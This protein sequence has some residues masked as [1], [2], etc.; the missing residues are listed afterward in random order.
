MA[1]LAQA[2]FSTGFTYQQLHLHRPRQVQVFEFIDALFAG[3]GL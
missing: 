2:R 1:I 3:R